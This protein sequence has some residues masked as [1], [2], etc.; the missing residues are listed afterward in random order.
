[1]IQSRSPGVESGLDHRGLLD[2]HWQAV[3]QTLAGIHQSLQTIPPW[4]TA[5]GATIPIGAGFFLGF[6]KA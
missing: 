1:L 4:L 3:D 6:K 2:V 5:L